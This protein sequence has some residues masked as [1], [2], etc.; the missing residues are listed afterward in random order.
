MFSRLAYDN[1]FN[2]SSTA[3]ITKILKNQHQKLHEP[4]SLK[5]NKSNFRTSQIGK[6]TQNMILTCISNSF[7]C[8]AALIIDVQPKR[9]WPFHLN[10]HLNV[11][12][13]NFLSFAS[14]GKL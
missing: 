1:C 8:G 10:V 2:S 5:T 9:L 11:M 14:I 7:N 12:K 13:T 4:E 3:S 6:R